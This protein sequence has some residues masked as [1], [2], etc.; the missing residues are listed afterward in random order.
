MVIDYPS[1]GLVY[2]KGSP[3]DNSSLKPRNWIDFQTVTS[4]AATKK[5][6]F[7]ILTNNRKWHFRVPKSNTWVADREVCMHVVAVVVVMLC[8][9]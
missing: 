8:C 9:C 5:Y 3:F 1:R 4:V 7:S 2:F 6:R